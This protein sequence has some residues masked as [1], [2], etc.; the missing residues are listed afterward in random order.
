[1]KKV[2]ALL[3]TLAMVLS[4]AACGAKE[5]TPAEKPAETPAA[6]SDA[7]SVYYL[8]FK[9]EAD[10]AWQDLAK[11]YTEQTGVEVKVVTAA[12]GE[13]ETN[14]TAE[15]AK[16]EAPTLF[17]CGNAQS[18]MT[19]GDYCLDLTGTDVLAEMTTSDFNLTEDGAVKAIG[20][21][22][23][24][25]GIIVNK[26]LL[27]EAGY[28]L[29]DITDFA[30]LKA[31]AED[32]HARSAEL[33]FDAFSSSGLDGSSSWRFSGHLAN[34]PLY[35]EF[36]DDGVTAQPAEITGA[37]LNNYRAIWDLYI[38]N[39]SAEKTSLTTA[40]GDMSSGEFKEKKAV[41][42]QNG[43]WEYAGLVEAGIA[44]EDLAMIPIYC[45]VDGESEAGLA[46]GTENCWAVNS[47]ASE[48]DI[49]ATLDFMKW[50]VTSDEGTQ[51]MA[52]QFGPIP[53]KNAK[54]SANVFFNDANA[55]MADGKYT[56]TWAFNHT[57][58]VDSWRSTVVSALATYSADQSDANWDGV[59][60]A[61]VDGWAYEYNMQN[62]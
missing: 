56:V 20:Y 4:L 42:Y 54:E 38:N 30:S 21:C 18:L 48:A 15:M 16:S 5:E 40:T 6:S 52:E 7:G 1:M 8:N 31:V 23:E 57:P 45:G 10:Q 49:Q 37:Y 19:W 17:Q 13:Y 35:Y 46:C 43:T 14:L 24:A 55:Y 26:A 47:Q 9:P 36:R 27:A 60:T 53:F 2:F 11:T 12:S 32:I 44:S 3:L 25:F 50:V 61:F 62:G 29:S 34:M 58:N 51:M 22:Y 39:S 59:V 41:F 28:E 33:G